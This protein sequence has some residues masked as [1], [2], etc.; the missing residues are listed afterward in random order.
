MKKC[1][2]YKITCKNNNKVYIGSSINI[3]QRW[4]AHRSGL[5]MA[6]HCNPNLLNSY[7]KYGLESL[8]FEILEE[9][10]TDILIEKETQWFEKYK[11]EG[12]EMFNYGDFI[13]NPTRGVSL[14]E[15]HK[16]KVSN[17]LKEFY[18]NNTVNNKGKKSEQWVCDKISES[19]MGHK[20]SEKSRNTFIEMA[21]S[22]KSEEHKKNLSK[23]KTE[24]IGIKVICF[25]TNEKFDSLI[26]AANHFDT[27]YQAIRQSIKR[28]GKCKGMIF[29][30]LE[31]IINN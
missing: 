1:G 4:S 19:Q 22:P 11:E 30:Y 14:T 29:K 23:T 5:K 6:K 20:V 12:Y 21:K 31:K 13:D 8:V 16:K 28:N 2:I 7:N 18:K 3:T 27:S 24:L 26:A 15:E 9:C 17:G 10:D 25:T